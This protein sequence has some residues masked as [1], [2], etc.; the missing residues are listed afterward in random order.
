MISAA[1]DFDLRFRFFFRTAFAKDDSSSSSADVDPELTVVNE[2]T[3]TGG[4][5]FGSLRKNSS[6]SSPN[7]QSFLSFPV[8]ASC[9]LTFLYFSSNFF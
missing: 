1:E 2:E 3:A 4:I 8:L 9:S 6:S 5:I 7:S